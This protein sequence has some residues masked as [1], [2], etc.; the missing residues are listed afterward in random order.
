MNDFF[1]EAGRSGRTGAIAALILGLILILAPGTAI[2]L[3]L[4]LAGWLILAMGIFQLVSGVSLSSGGTI[5]AGALVALLGFWVIRNPGNIVSSLVLVVGIVLLLH[6]VTDLRH[7][8]AARQAGA[9]GW[10]S[11]ALT[12]AVTLILALMLILNPFGTAKSVIRLAG[13]CLLVDGGGE[14]LMMNRMRGYF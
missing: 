3:V 1:R 4:R 14:L 11:A 5:A 6:G 9:M 7:A 10:W 8:F 13:V 12:G 2:S